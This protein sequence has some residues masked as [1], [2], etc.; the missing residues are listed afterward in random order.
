MAEESCGEETTPVV[1][2]APSTDFAGDSG[3]SDSLSAAQKSIKFMK[4]RLR[5]RHDEEV[6]RGQGSMDGIDG[7]Q[8]LFNPNSFTQTVENIFHFVSEYCLT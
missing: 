7:V 1:V 3:S 4:R 5:E 8:F 2:V 6:R